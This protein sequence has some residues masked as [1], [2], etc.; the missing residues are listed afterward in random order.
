MGISHEKVFLESACDEL[1]TTTFYRELFFFS[2]AFIKYG[3]DME[4]PVTLSREGGGT[5]RSCKI[6]D[7]GDYLDRDDTYVPA[8]TFFPRKLKNG[9]YSSTN[10]KETASQLCAFVLD[11]DRGDSDA[12]QSCIDEWRSPGALLTPTFV[13]CSGSGFHLYYVLSQP[14]K[15]LKRWQGELKAINSFL[16]SIYTGFDANGRSLGEIDRHGLTQPYRMVGSLAKNGKDATSAWR[17]GDPCA[18]EDLARAAGLEQEEFTEES[19]DMSR[20]L[21]TRGW[22][23]YV[24]N[25]SELQGKGTGW[26]PGFYAWLARREKERTRLYGEYGHRY[27]QVQALTIASIKDRIPRVRLEADVREL[28]AAWNECARRYGHPEIGWDECVKAMNSFRYCQ[29]AMRFPKWWMEELCGWE[30]GTQKRNGRDRWTHL[31]AGTWVHKTKKGDVEGINYCKVARELN[32]GGRPKGS[33]KE[34]TPKGEM[35]RGYA[36]AHPDASHSEIARALGVSRP[37]VIK[38]L[39][40]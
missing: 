22:E 37:T 2:D 15:M 13:V 14:V 17:V 11:L 6:R 28:H 34:S 12:L 24:A 38:W 39:N 8:C 1:D 5:W 31:Q 33:V 3:L 40:S 9:R 23:S 21:K 4:V 25:H 18:I 16:Y 27:K 36:K 30:F 35:I 26:N 32:P 20:S 10:S 7:F 19:F 29:T